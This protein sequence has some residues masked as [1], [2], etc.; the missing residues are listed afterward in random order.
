MTVT[1]TISHACDTELQSK[2]SCIKHDC[3]TCMC[4]VYDLM[5]G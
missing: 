3:R 5:Q 4:I 1:M 2:K